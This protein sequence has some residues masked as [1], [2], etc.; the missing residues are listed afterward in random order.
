[1]TFV[2]F[3]RGGGT[4]EQVSTILTSSSEYWQA[5]SGGT[6]DGFVTALY[7]DTFNRS[8]GPGELATYTNALDAGASPRRVA[9]GILGSTQDFLDAKIVFHSVF[10]RLLAHGAGGKLPQVRELQHA[11]R[12]V[13]PLPVRV[14]RAEHL[15]RLYFLVGQVP[16]AQVRDNTSALGAINLD[17]AR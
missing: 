17:P 13:D 12:Q 5:R 10:G 9:S 6:K 4:P 15:D 8:P 11:G 16:A 3:L 2:T 1:N 7:Q 14:P